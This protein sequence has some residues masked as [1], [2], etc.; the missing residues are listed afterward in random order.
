VAAGLSAAALALTGCGSGGG[1]AGGGGGEFSG[2]T[3]NVV[4][5]WSGAEQENF[6]AVLAEFSSRTGAKVNYT[7]FGDNGPTYIQGQ[8]EGGTPPNVAV[9]GQPALMQS[10]AQNG[11]IVPVGDGVRSAVEEHYA[12]C[13]SRARTSRPS[14]TT[15][16]STTRRA[17]PSP[18]TGTTS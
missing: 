2:E 4:A 14:G 10:L 13:G 16:T 8:L 15:P 18:R 7:S 11:D 12:Q 6:E 1:G 9:L 17:P 3:L 5:A